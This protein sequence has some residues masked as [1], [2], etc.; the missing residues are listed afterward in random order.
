MQEIAASKTD[1][2]A[3]PRESERDWEEDG[4]RLREE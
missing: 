1:S 3:L 4:D 2:P